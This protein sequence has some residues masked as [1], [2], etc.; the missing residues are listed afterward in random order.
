MKKAGLVGVVAGLHVCLIGAVVFLAQ[1][2]GTTK[3]TVPPEKGATVMPPP[4]PVTQP[5]VVR[6]IPPPPANPPS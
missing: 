4:V 6:P 1:G 5:M 3:T 2:C